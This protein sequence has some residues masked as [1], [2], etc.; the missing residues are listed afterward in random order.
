MLRAPGD[1]LLLLRGP[2]G[3][4]LELVTSCEPCVMCLGATALE[5]GSRLVCGA[6]KAGCRGAGLRRGPGGCRRVDHLARRGVAVVARVLRKK[7][8]RSAPLPGAGRPSMTGVPSASPPVR[9]TLR[10]S[11]IAR[12]SILASP[13]QPRRGRSGHGAVSAP[14]VA[15]Q[16]GAR[17]TPPLE[18]SLVAAYRPPRATG[19]NDCPECQVTR[20]STRRCG[21]RGVFKTT[22]GGTTGRRSS[23]AAGVLIGFIGRGPLRPERGVRRTG[24]PISEH[25]PWLGGL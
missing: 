18:E 11:L 14:L 10:R 12:T 7:Q 3:P 20:W 21:I 22:D 1:R 13:A 17:S 19:G 16:G 23:T 9:L 25:I 6:T 5:R 15:Q 8:R 2:R 4:P 24:E